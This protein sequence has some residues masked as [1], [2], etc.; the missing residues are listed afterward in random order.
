MV[1]GAW[2]H[3]MIW[4]SVVPFFSFSLCRALSRQFPTINN[5]YFQCFWFSQAQTTETRISRLGSDLFNIIW[6]TWMGSG[7]IIST[8]TSQQKHIHILIRFSHLNA[9]IIYLKKRDTSL[10]FREAKLHSIIKFK[11]H[12]NVLVALLPYVISCWF[13]LAA[14]VARDWCTWRLSWIWWKASLHRMPKASTSTYMS[15]ISLK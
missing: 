2:L 10:F 6:N 13:A 7:F 3:G 1:F 11:W 12:W 5:W 8:N 14:D 4:I 15:H 9:C